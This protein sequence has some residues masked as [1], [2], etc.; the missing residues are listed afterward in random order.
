MLLFQTRLNAFTAQNTFRN[1]PHFSGRGWQGSATIVPEGW[2]HCANVVEPGTK[3]RGT[4]TKLI[5]VGTNKKFV[6]GWA[7]SQYRQWHRY[8]RDVSGVVWSCPLVSRGTDV[9]LFSEFLVDSSPKIG[10]VPIPSIWVE[11]GTLRVG[12]APKPPC[13]PPLSVTNGKELQLSHQLGCFGP[14]AR[15]TRT[16]DL[17]I[18]RSLKLLARSTNESSSFSPILILNDDVRSGGLARCLFV[19]NNKML[20]RKIQT[21]DIRCRKILWT[22]SLLSKLFSTK[23]AF[24]SLNELSQLSVS[25]GTNSVILS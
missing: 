6:H 15:V 21:I 8:H 7:F 18:F 13:H 1:F 20:C 23:F 11:P 10:G 5:W 22:M 2:Y 14:V 19:D 12:P 16:Q 4:G 25:A 17:I 9:D 24:V 3:G